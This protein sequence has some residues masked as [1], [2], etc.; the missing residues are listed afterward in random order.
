MN[1]L[2]NLCTD[3]AVPCKVWRISRYLILH[4]VSLYLFSEGQLTLCFAGTFLFL[5]LAFGGTQAVKINHASSGS[6]PK[7]PT[8]VVPTPEILLYESLSAGFSLTVNVWAF[9][10][11]TGAFFNPAITL[12]CV[13]VGKVPPLKGVLMG[14]AQLI[15]GIAAAGLVEGLTP[16]KLA[17]GTGL[18]GE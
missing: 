8:R 15:G 7:D 6:F 18:A 4:F 3:I 9:Y 14:I 11:V 13:L 5:S 10:R 2:K 1:G 12:G 17:V 16:G